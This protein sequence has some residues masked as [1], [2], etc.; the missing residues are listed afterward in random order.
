MK[1]QE[2]ESEAL[3]EEGI[4]HICNAFNVKYLGPWCIMSNGS[5][6]EKPV[7]V[8][9]NPNP[10]ISRGHSNYLGVFV[11]HPYTKEDV[12]FTNAES[13]FQQ[14]MAAIEEDGVV[15]VSRYRHDSITTPNGLHIDGGRDYCKTN[16]TTCISVVMKDGQIELA[17]KDIGMVDEFMHHFLKD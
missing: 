12:A 10:D 8:F 13:A 6:T 4:D 5:W 1:L 15:Y 17:P 3:T 2:R 11:S 16:T 9:Y 7:D 14:P